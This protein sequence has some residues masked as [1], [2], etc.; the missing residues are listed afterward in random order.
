MNRN[1]ITSIVIAL[2]L[3]LGFSSPTFAQ[4]GEDTLTL[5]LNRDF[6]YGGF[7]GKIQ[8]AFSMRA[9]GPAD[10]T[11]VVYFIDDQQI[12]EASAEPFNFQFH[13]G[14]FDPGVHTLYAI[15]YTGAGQELRSN[16]IR[17]HFISSEDAGKSTLGIV[18]PILVIV[19]GISVLGILLPLITG[20]QEKNRPIG[21]Y[22]A[23]GAT[24]CKHCGLPFSR[25]F[26]AP[27]LLTGKLE[28]CPHCGKWQ[29]AARAY[30]SF[31]TLAE[32]RL[33]ADRDEGVMQVE[34]SEEEK[35]RRMLDESR[36]DN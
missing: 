17:A 10:L 27:N 26:F 12:G 16:E 22:S 9:S 28:R 24:V 1:V 13:T 4:E 23:A 35:I 3:L 14:S 25:H 8:G 6:G 33:R 21:Q 15:G 20:R 7:D 31:L 30:G 36:F 5:H 19:V 29:L 18:V 34:E 2:V 11:R 32:E